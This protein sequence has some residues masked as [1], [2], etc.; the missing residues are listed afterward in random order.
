MMEFF[1]ARRKGQSFSSNSI[2]RTPVG[3]CWLHR[4]SSPSRANAVLELPHPIISTIRASSIPSLSYKAMDASRS[5]FCVR[6]R[7]PRVALWLM[8]DM[9]QR[10]VRMAAATAVQRMV[11]NDWWWHAL[12]SNLDIQSRPRVSIRHGLQAVRVAR[13]AAWSVTCLTRR[14]PGKGPTGAT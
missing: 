13:T 5:A 1:S 11:M 9:A 12:L 3:K 7:S 8:S 4:S 10:T 6:G 2:I 14:G